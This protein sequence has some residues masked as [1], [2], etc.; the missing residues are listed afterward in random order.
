[1]VT[2]ATGFIASRIVLDLLEAGYKV[3][4]TVRNL[5]R[6]EELKSWLA[7]LTGRL[8]N[9]TLHA[10]ELLSDDGW[11]QAMAGCKY[12][13]H[14]ASP[15]PAAPPENE[16]DLIRPAVEGT[17]RVLKAALRS[18]VQ[19]V[20]LTSSLAAMTYGHPNRSRTFTEAD[21]SKLD[22]DIEPYQKSKTL[23]E[24]AA[25]DF[26]NSLPE[27]KSLELVAI[28]PGYV[29][30]PVIND[31]TPTSITLHKML[32]EGAVP[33]VARIKFD[34]VDVRDVSRLHLAAM[35]SKEAAGKRFLCVGGAIWLPEIAKTLSDHFRPRGYRV[36]RIQF[37]DLAVHLF[38]LVNQEA[39][40]VA[41]SVGHD[42]NFD[43]SQARE[44]LNWTPL[45]LDQ[46]I[47]EMGES[48]IEF[49]LIKK[50]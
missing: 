19:R 10:A 30:G 15:F 27:G 35:T 34:L 6:E 25:W 5:E 16:D 38:A 22:G 3:R 7:P 20:V 42:P 46:T 2:G 39:S 1:L 40:L 18:R 31:R 43:T 49:G 11:D 37:P 45:P 13:L 12:V 36:P 28:C 14:T 21:W 33:G 47:I 24:Q 8:D 9:L 29:I 41:K 32:M 50:K 44:I 23:A 26:V 17:L 4:G 48:L